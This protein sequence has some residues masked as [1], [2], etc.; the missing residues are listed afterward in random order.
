LSPKGAVLN[1][2]S[3]VKQCQVSFAKKEIKPMSNFIFILGGARSGKSSYAI[4]LAKGLRAKVAYIATCINSDDKEMKERIKLHKKARPRHWKVIEEGKDV[5]LVLN[6]LNQRYNVVIIDCLAL[7]ISNFLLGNLSDS[8]IFRKL[9]KLTLCI[10]KSKILTI[11]V[12]NEVGSG[13]VPD[14]FL[15][16]RFRDLVGLANQM[17]AKEADQVIFMQSGIPLKIKDTVQ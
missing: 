1:S 8:E 14:N 10:T 3:I 17:M 2:N 9:K 7:L 16:R 11:V 15:A 13:I 5:S 12:S 4:E 6:K